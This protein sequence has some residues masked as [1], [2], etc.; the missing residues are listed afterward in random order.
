VS[1]DTKVSK[2]TR[3]ALPAEQYEAGLANAL[4][5]ETYKSMFRPKGMRNVQYLSDEQRAIYNN[6]RLD[7]SKAGTIEGADGTRLVM[8]IYIKKS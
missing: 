6:A 3:I 4:D 1:K 7:L 5:Q 8:G 2:D